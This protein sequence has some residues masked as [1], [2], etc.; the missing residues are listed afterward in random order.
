MK[1]QLLILFLS[2]GFYSNACDCSKMLTAEWTKNGIIESISNSEVIIIGKLI[3]STEKSYKLKIVEVFKGKLKKGEILE[4]F[5]PSSCS[6]RP[7]P[8]KTGHWIFYGF[9]EK[10]E[11]EKIL[12]YSSCGPTRS[13]EY[14]TIYSKK[15]HKKFWMEELKILNKRLN[16]SIEFEMN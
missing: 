2:I 12:N 9:Y 15:E 5:Y 16:K 11:N 14:L 8:K 10:F 3:S 7:H 13:L 1:K 4:G 6:G